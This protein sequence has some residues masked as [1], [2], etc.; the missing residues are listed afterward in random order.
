MTIHFRQSI[1]KTIQERRSVRTYSDQ[2]LSTE[3]KVE[4]DSFLAHLSNPFDSSIHYT[5]FHLSE[6]AEPKKLGTY[7]VIKGAKTYIG[8]ALTEDANAF[9]ALGYEFEKI[10]LFLTDRGLGSCWLGG[11]FN[12]SEFSKLMNLQDGEI[13]P[14]MSP[15]GSAE[16]KRSLTDKLVRYIAKGDS[17]KPWEELFFNENFS[18]PLKK[19][20]AGALSQVFESVRLAPSASNKQPWRIIKTESGYHFYESPTPGYSKAFSY[21]IQRID[22]GIAASHFELAATELGLGLKLTQLMDPVSNFPEGFVYCFS[23]C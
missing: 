9:L 16:E 10:I 12:R 20:Q 22:M 1:I 14:I 5:L 3:Q 2:E 21:D 8:A 11:T 23:F 4:L 15:I 6:A 7:G 18:T 19:E 13:F 17:R